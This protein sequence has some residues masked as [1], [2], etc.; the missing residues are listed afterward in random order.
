V[1][2]EQDSGEKRAIKREWVPQPQLLCL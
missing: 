2:C 1:V